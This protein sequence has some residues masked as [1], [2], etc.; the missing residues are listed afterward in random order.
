METGLTPRPEPTLSVRNSGRKP[1]IA[2]RLLLSEKR[3]KKAKKSRFLPDVHGKRP[4]LN[5]TS[6]ST[7]G[8]K[9]APVGMPLLL[10][11]GK[12]IDWSCRCA[13]GLK[14]LA[15]MASSTQKFLHTNCARKNLRIHPAVVEGLAT[16]SNRRQAPPVGLEPTTRR[17]TAACSTN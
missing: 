4:A 9:R 1:R 6:R 11:S 14:A 2:I 3:R 15:A 17:L 10:S 5:V 12:R 13:S 16:H 7:R 8:K